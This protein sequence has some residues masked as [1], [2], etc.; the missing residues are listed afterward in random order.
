MLTPHFFTL[1]NHKI[2][3]KIIEDTLDYVES[4]IHSS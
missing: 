1:T 4:F 3:I 2:V